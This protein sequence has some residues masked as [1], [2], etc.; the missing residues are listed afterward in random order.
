MVRSLGILLVGFVLGLVVR[1]LMLGQSVPMPSEI[2]SKVTNS[3]PTSSTQSGG[4]ML[5]TAVIYNNTGF[6]PSSV[7]VTRGNYLTITNSSDSLMW[8][9]S[10]N[11]QFETPRGYGKSEQLKIKPDKV[12]EFKVTNKLNLRASS[13]S[14]SVK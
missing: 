11:P 2:L 4:D 14:V 5:I 3:L 8:L 9:S 6:T 1:Q 12:G 13:L 7:R 10:D